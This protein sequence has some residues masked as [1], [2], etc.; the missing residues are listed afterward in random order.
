MKIQVEKIRNENPY[1]IQK[2]SLKFKIVS[3][4]LKKHY[5][6]LARMSMFFNSKETNV[7]FI[8]KGDEDKFYALIKEINNSN[9]KRCVS[10]H[11]KAVEKRRSRKSNSVCEHEDLGSLGYKHGETISCP[12][13]GKKAVVW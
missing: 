1:I 10:S 9:D 13:C 4:V 11:K 2:C 7:G 5:K 12:H 6:A 3:S 8:K